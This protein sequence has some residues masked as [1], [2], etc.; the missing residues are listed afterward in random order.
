MFKVTI[1]AILLCCGV[2]G[3]SVVKHN[4]YA[5]S[6]LTGYSIISTCSTVSSIFLDC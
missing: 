5:C 4:Y 1:R 6:H 2:Q 3:A